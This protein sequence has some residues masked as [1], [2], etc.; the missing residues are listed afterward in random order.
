MNERRIGGLERPFICMSN[1]E[2]HGDPAISR[3]FLWELL[4]TT[5]LHAK[6]NRENRKEPTAAFRIGSATH[7]AILE[8]TEF[9]RQIYVSGASRRTKAGKAAHESLTGEGMIVLT[10]AEYGLVCGMRDAVAV[11]PVAKHVFVGGHAES[12]LFATD[13]RTG[14]RIK[15]RYDYVMSN[16][17]FGDL[18][19][20][21]D[22]SPSGFARSVF[23]YGY[24]VQAAHYMRVA[25]LNG[26][27]PKGFVFVAVEKDPPHAVACYH[28]DED[29]IHRGNIALEKALD[30]YVYCRDNDTWQGYPDYLM[31]IETSRHYGRN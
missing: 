14:V 17:A 11:H 20:T 29:V 27:D 8:P 4:T 26:L 21:D 12:S 3:S 19:T 13:L 6:W 9:E 23:K 2:Y 28:A 22:A 15:A 5:P 10:P 18:K 24:H 31:P 16:L 7:L 30:L 25:K 1:S